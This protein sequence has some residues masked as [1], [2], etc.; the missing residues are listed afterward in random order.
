MMPQATLFFE[1][2]KLQDKAQKEGMEDYESIRLTHAQIQNCIAAV[3]N[4]VLNSFRIIFRYSISSN[5]VG[6][7]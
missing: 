7:S 2:A 5:L 1:L 3:N 6:V 4:Q